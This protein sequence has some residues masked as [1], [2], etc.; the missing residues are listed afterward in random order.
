MTL[1]T[2]SERIGSASPI[3]FSPHCVIEIGGQLL[4][5]WR[6]AQYMLG[7]DIT[8]STGSA[9]MAEWSVF[10]PDNKYLSSWIEGDGLQRLEMKIWLG[11][12]SDLG[13]PV[14]EGVLASTEWETD[15][16]TFR[17]YDYGYWMRQE[18]RAEYHK[19]LTDIEIIGKLAQRNGLNFVRPVPDIKLDKHPSIIQSGQSDWEFAQERAQDAGLVL[20]VR[21]KT[22]YASEAAKSGTPVVSLIH[23]KDYELLAGTSFRYVTPENVAGR[24][25]VIEVRG[26]G[27]GGKRLAGQSD[28]SERGTKRLAVGRDLAIKTK[29]SANRRAQAIKDLQREHAYTGSITL[30]PDFT[31]V[32]PDI[33]DTVEI[34][35]VGK[36]FSGRYIV[37]EV[38]HIFGPGQLETQIELYRDVC[39]CVKALKGNNPNELCYQ[40]CK[41]FQQEKQEREREQERVTT[42]VR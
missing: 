27:R 39:D 3:P 4:D 16:S 20:Y 25:S 29:R 17:C 23:G 36:M 2:T 22:L 30:L 6:D 10:D 28:K 11:F 19:N 35:N 41:K 13:K 5:S 18:Q 31:G 14:F 42:Y 24:N 8:L 21:G 38:Q 37:D 26:R 32:R 1:K 34:L 40:R 33:R 9:S 12:T 15:R 7:A